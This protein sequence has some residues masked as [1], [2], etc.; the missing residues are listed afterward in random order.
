MGKESQVLGSVFPDY[1][2]AF[3]AQAFDN[4]LRSQGLL[5]IHWRAMRCPGGLVDINDIRRPHED[6]ADCSGGF[7]YKKMGCVTGLLT[8]NSTNN[9]NNDIGLLNGST[10]QVSFPRSYDDPKEKQVY[11]LPY[12]RFYL[13]DPTILTAE[14]ML[15]RAHESGIDKGRFPI[16]KVDHIIDSSLVEYGCESYTIQAGKVVWKPG[17]GP[18]PGTVYTL[19]YQYQ[20]YWYVSQL[21]HEIRVSGTRDY[22]TGAAGVTRMPFAAHLT[23]ENIHQ[24]E[25]ND[26][27]APNDRT[28]PAP[29]DGGFGAR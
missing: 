13:N 23:R 26:G 16:V 11:V 29:A 18:A 3:D 25:E 17:A 15:V 12:D 27:S 4:A 20:P 5:L 9:Q 22:V 14:W 8:S 1:R 21:I 19:W 24:S 10:I 7:L 2:I 28:Q 6:H